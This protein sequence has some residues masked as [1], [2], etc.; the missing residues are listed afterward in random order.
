[1]T[2]QEF[3][4][5]YN[6]KQVD[7]DNYPTYDKTQCVDLLKKYYPEVLGVP[8]IR[9]NGGDYFA[10]SPS[11]QFLKFYNTPTGVPRPGDVMVWKKTAVLPFGHVGIVT[12]AN[13][14]WFE[15]FEQN[16]PSAASPCH[17]VRHSYI[18]TYPVL[19]WVRKK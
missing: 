14:F 16:W 3:I 11:A 13:V 10:N 8:A 15:T 17:I 4:N 5:K 19:G 1:M 6:W 12:R 9:G 18:G 7:V 2:L